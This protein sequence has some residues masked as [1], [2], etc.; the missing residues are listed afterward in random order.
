MNLNYPAELPVSAEREHIIEAIRN[1]QVV[2]IAGETG[3]GKTT[4]L[5][6]MCLE[7]NPDTRGMIGCTQPRRIAATSVAARVKE[8]LGPL[9]N[10]VGSKIRFHDRTTKETKIK[11]MTDG[12]LLAESRRDKMF[13]RY[14]TIIIDEAHERSL[15]IDFL[16]GFLR[17]LITKRSDLKLL[18]TS[19]TIDTEAFSRHFDNAPIINV[20]GRDWPVEIKYLP[21]PEEQKDDNEGGVEHCVSAVREIFLARPEGDILIFLPTERD[22]RECCSLLEGT[23]PGAIVLPLFG[24]LA[25]GEQSRIFKAAHG[26]KIIV[27]TNVAETSLTVP[28]IRYVIDSGTARISQYNVRA[29]TTSLPI[30]RISQA[31]ANQRA[32]RAGRIG[33]GTCLRLYSE[34]DFNSRAEFTVPEIKRSN[35]AEVILQMTSLD[36]GDPEDFPF[37]DPPHSSAIREGYRLLKELGAIS[38]QGKL[39]KRGR[40]MADLPVDPCIS[41]VL[42]EAKELNCVRET[43]IICSVLAIQDPRIR[44]TEEEQPADEKHRAFRDEKSDFITLLNIWNTCFAGDERRSW[45]NLK[46]FCKANY[47]SFQRMRE[48]FDLRE[49]LERILS[50]LDGFTP[51]TE[52]AGFEAIHKSILTGFLRNIAKKKEEPKNASNK[53]GNA[54]KSPPRRNKMQIY[55]GGQNKELLIFPGSG[56]AK[57]QPEWI[58]AATF[59]ETSRLYALTVA[60]IEPQW[61]E[62]AAGHLCTFSWSSPFWQKRSGQVRATE[63]VSLFGLI[64][65]AG[66]RVNFPRRNRRNIPEARQIFIQQGLVPGEINGNYAFLTHNLELVHK[67]EQSEARLRTRNLVADEQTLF[68]FYDERLPKDVYDQHQLNRF[69]KQDKSRNE[70]LTMTE[71]HVLLRDFEEK[72]LYDFPETRTIGGL[73]LRL[74]YNF[75][76]GSESD[77][78]T[79]RLPLQFAL[80]LD[81]R[82]FAWLVPGLLEEKLTWYLKSLV[83]SL[84]RRLVPIQESV[85]IILDEI[86]FGRGDLLAAIESA[87]LKQYRMNIH[88][89]DWKEDLPAHLRPRYLIFDDQD[90]TVAAG[91]D[92]QALVEKAR[93][94]L[95]KHPQ[96]QQSAPASAKSGSAQKESAELL[97]RWRDGEYRE[98]DFAGLPEK[99]PSFTAA[100]EISGFLFPALRPEVQKGCVSLVFEKE[101]QQAQ[102]INRNGVLSLFSLQFREPLKS[103]KRLI[104][105]ALSGPSTIFLT[106]LKMGRAELAELVLMQ[107]L[108]R[109]YGD[110]ET[111]IPGKEEF[112]R[113]IEQA[114]EAGFYKIGQLYLDQFMTALRKRR[115][116]NEQLSELFIKAGKKGHKLPGRMKKEFEGELQD[117]FPATLLLSTQMVDYSLVKRELQYLSIRLE[118]FYT[119][120]Q[121]DAIKAEQ[122]ENFCKRLEQPAAHSPRTAEAAEALSRYREMLTEF[123]ISI[124]SPELKK[125]MPVSSKKLEAQWQEFLK[126]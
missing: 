17:Q 77:G 83:K 56:L 119:N 80:N 59:L 97:S 124:F 93:L 45:N 22:I 8:E 55:Q 57:K 61:I 39:T 113:R 68:R 28:G 118:R 94:H 60:A 6:K 38:G 29:K 27:A 48:W 75:E 33:P 92:L 74:E 89:S 64:L 121:K 19:A 81:E 44:P 123:K 25:S 107:T 62:A 98:W 125:R 73:T 82:P 14:S 50:R 116:V 7:A 111:G 23:Y 2:I 36:L 21:L 34:E 109:I 46:K 40:I 76:P 12:V 112:E 67:W 1:N 100:G 105:T 16:L 32:G 5:P 91:R 99:I 9:Q 78:V 35:L 69:L 43:T 71:E 95:L 70:Q 114:K 13:R 79:F 84:R 87:I 96:K 86:E 117:I 31:S 72:E 103:L 108:N 54:I 18:I 30:S 52:A 90:K 3:S 4:Q 102:R 120:P 41:R 104:T 10:L 26:I 63:S 49:Q 20:T 24:R 53:S 110:T 122:I 51:N 66:R 37:I 101:Q 15:N 58:I 115:E 85:D 47:L 42:L 65:N 106:T 11:F 88:R 126:R